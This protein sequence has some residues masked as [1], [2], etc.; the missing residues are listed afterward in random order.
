MALCDKAGVTASSFLRCAALS[1]PLTR[2][3]RRPTVAHNE[4]ARLSGELGQLAQVLRDM[5][6]QLTDAD[7]HHTALIENALIELSHLGSATLQAL[8]RGPRS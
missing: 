8:G 6:H 2:A 1:H 7:Q 4:V 5:L 3:T